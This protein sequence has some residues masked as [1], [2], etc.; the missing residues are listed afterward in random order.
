M[1]T[2]LPLLPGES[3]IPS[4]PNIELDDGTNCI[5]Q[6]YLSYQ[7]TIESVSNIVAEIEYDQH[8]LLFVD[9]DNG[10]IFL[11]VGIVGLDNYV[12]PQKQD[13]H[14]IVY[15]RRWRVEANLPSSE[16]I[17]TAFLALC[18]AREHEIRELVKWRN[19]INTTTPFSCHHDLP[20]MAMS[21]STKTQINDNQQAQSLS[22]ISSQNQSS[23]NQSNQPHN[24]EM[25]AHEQSLAHLFSSISY[26]G[27]LFSLQG[28]TPIDDTNYLIKIQLHAQAICKLPETQKDMSFCLLLESLNQDHVLYAFMD[29]LLALSNRHVEE[30]FSFK[31][32]TRFSRTNSIEKIAAL[33]AKTRKLETIEQQST[34]KELLSHSNYETD[35]TRVPKLNAGK[36]GRKLQQQL[37]LLNVGSGILPSIN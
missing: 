19:G 24:C 27:A 20:L 21:S 4:A 34:F 33:S 7:H 30:H 11:Q 31:G 35:S 5:P 10:G 14:K 32:Y 26:D 36:L 3:P 37:A 17:Q 8:Y 12:C 25:S 16:I 13:A 2:P 9:Q 28:I 18:K 1:K 22:T 29:K 15:G 23:K 6:H